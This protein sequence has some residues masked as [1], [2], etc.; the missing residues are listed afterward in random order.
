MVSERAAGEP[1]RQ[2]GSLTSSAARSETSLCPRRRPGLMHQIDDRRRAAWHWQDEL[3]YPRTRSAN[4]E[5]VVRGCEYLHW[6]LRRWAGLADAMWREWVELR[7]PE[8][9]ICHVFG[10]YC[11]EALR[12]SWCESRHTTTAH[13]GQYLGLF[14]MGYWERRRFGHGST[15]LEQARAAYRYFVESGRDW[16]P[17][18][19]RWAA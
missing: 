6:V 9:A 14:Q 17:W 10:E 4:R 1:L 16:S 2:G 11:S 3:G 18:S 5:H 7:E 12:V 15:A 13:N 8:A 19:C